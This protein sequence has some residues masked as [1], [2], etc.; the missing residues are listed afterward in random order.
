MLVQLNKCIVVCGS[1]LYSV[2]ATVVTYGD[3]VCCSVV[4]GILVGVPV[5]SAM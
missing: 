4:F 5:F 2:S 3:D 1:N